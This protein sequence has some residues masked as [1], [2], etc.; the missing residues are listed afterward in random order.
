MAVNSTVSPVIGLFCAP[1]SK[2]LIGDGIRLLN[3]ANDFQLHAL[4]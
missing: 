3:P 4:Y 1:A 2:T